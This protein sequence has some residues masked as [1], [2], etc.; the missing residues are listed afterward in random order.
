MLPSLNSHLKKLRKNNNNIYSNLNEN[1]IFEEIKENGESSDN[2]ESS[3]SV[4]L[5]E[6]Y[7][8]YN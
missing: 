8:N 4:D 3:F 7:I 5:E 6:E 1:K 2:N